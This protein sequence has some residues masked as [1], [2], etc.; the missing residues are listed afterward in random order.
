MKGY[1][2]RNL[3][4]L[5]I[6]SVLST[7]FGWATTTDALLC[8]TVYLLAYILRVLAGILEIFKNKKSWK[9]KQNSCSSLRS[10]RRKD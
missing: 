1:E 7:V 3:L 2:I 10:G 5:I 4:I 8:I 6:L 9:Q